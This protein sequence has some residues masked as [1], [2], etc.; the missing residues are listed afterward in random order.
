MDEQ[1][2][3]LK[4]VVKF[5]FDTFQEYERELGSEVGGSYSV[6]ATIESVWIHIIYYFLI[7]VLNIW[8]CR[9]T[10]LNKFWRTH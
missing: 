9:I 4:F 8:S 5:I 2:D 7:C 1:P 10:I 3:Y 6:K